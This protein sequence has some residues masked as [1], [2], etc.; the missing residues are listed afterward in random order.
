MN[1]SLFNQYRQKMTELLLLREFDGGILPLEVESAFVEQ[2]DDLWWQL[3]DA[4][5]EALEYELKS[6]LTLVAPE[7]LDLVDRSVPTGGN[8]APRKAA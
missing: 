2:L 4:Q 3:T 7:R 6:S 8:E 5:Q 1:D